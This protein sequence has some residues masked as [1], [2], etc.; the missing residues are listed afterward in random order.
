MPAGLD[1]DHQLGADPVGS[2]HENRIAETGALEVEQPAEPADFRIGTRAGGCAHQRLDQVHHAVAGV[3]IDAGLRVGQAIA[4]V[5][6]G[7]GL[8]RN[9]GP[10]NGCR[11]VVR[12]RRSAPAWQGGAR[13]VICGFLKFL[14]GPDV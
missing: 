6:H 3:D 4:L 10:C 8:R 5:V 14:P 13:G 9:G 11:A 7:V 12:K 1:R 2:S